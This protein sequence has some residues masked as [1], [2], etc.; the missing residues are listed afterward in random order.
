[1]QPEESVQIDG[2]IGRA[3]RPRNRDGRAQIVIALLR[4]AAPRRSAR[5]PRRAGRSPPGSSCAGWAHR[6]RTARGKATAGVDPMPNIAIAELFKKIL[7]VVMTAYSLSSSENPATR[8]PNPLPTRA[9]TRSDSCPSDRPGP[10]RSL[11]AVCASR[12]GE[13]NLPRRLR[14]IVRESRCV[15]LHALHLVLRQR[16]REIHAPQQ[17][18]RVHPLR[19]GARITGR[20]DLAVQRLA[21]LSRSAV[22]AETRNPLRAGGAHRAG[23]HLERRFHLGPI[24]AREKNSFES[25]MVFITSRISPSR[26]AESLGHA[27][28]QRGGGSS[29]T[30][31]WA[32]FLRNESRGGGMLGQD[33]EHLFAV[34][35]AAAGGNGHAQHDFLAFIV[36]PVVVDKIRRPA[37]DCEWSSR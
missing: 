28:D 35:L 18:R 29:A 9:W 17:R 22:P 24:R 13:Q 7:R 36:H 8:A 14:G 26:V 20:L 23:D 3:V 4:R 37:A 10:S 21:Q 31:R 34:F 15:H 16:Q 19:V 12:I 33:I 27:I 1:M 30:K 5:P 11:L 2:R 25:N 32:S 6:P